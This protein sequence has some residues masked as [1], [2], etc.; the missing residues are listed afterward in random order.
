MKKVC[1]ENQKKETKKEDEKRGALHTR[2][3]ERSERRAPLLKKE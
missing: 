2:L 1:N 3:L